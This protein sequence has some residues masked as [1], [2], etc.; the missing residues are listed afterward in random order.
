M[1]CKQLPS[2]GKIKFRFLEL[3]Y[4]FFLNIFNPRLV[5]STDVEPA[6]MEGQLHFVSYVYFQNPCFIH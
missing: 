2:Q 3:W 1:L 6:D 4:F 5:E